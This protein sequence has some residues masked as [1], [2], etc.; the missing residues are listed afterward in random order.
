MVTLEPCDYGGTT[1]ILT[2]KEQRHS[3]S[4]KKGR[5]KGLRN[6]LA[7]PNLNFWPVINVDQYP[8][9]LKNLNIALPSIKWPDKIPMHVY[10][11]VSKEDRASIKKKMLEKVPPKPDI[12]K[13]MIMGIN[14]V[15]RA[16]EKDDICCVLLDANVEPPLMIKHI[17]IMAMNKKIPVILLP[18]LKIVTLEKLGFATT[19]FALKQE[20][21]Q[22]PDNVCHL[23]YKSIAKASEDFELPEC[24]LKPDEISD[25]K[26]IC[27]PKITDMDCDPI[28]SISKPE[29]PITVFTTVY[30]YRSLKNKRAFIPPT[31][32]QTS[33]TEIPSDEFIALSNDFVSI[34]DK[35]SIKTLK[36]K[37]Y[38]DISEDEKNIEEKQLSSESK[39][40]NTDTNSKHVKKHK[41]KEYQTNEP[42]YL[43]LKI[44]RIQG[45][46]KRTKATKFP[47]KKMKKQ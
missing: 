7:Q 2:K 15:T 42:N 23:L 21:M 11:K 9:L 30:K 29:I 33:L 1:P 35:N 27:E 31:I 17:I 40:I 14:A 12:L 38:V 24:L 39:L 32:N 16:L 18:T 6:I 46:N 47:K 5:A 28:P 43:P 19:A 34:N 25:K 13:F 41:L 44:K 3:L 36:N 20:V 10:K 37:R 4:A 26:I 8:E 45:N 22:C